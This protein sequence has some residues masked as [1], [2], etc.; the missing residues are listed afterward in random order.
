MRAAGAQLIVVLSHM[1]HEELLAEL[2]RRVLELGGVRV[3]RKRHLEPQSDGGFRHGG[4]VA[5]TLADRRWAR[6]LCHAPGRAP[7]RAAAGDRRVG[8]LGRR[9]DAHG[10]GSVRAAMIPGRADG[11]AGVHG[12]R[13]ELVMASL[14]GE[15]SIA[16]LCR[17]PR[18][19][20]EMLAQW[21]ADDDYQR[22]TSHE[23]PVIVRERR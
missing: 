20:Q 6:Q 22:N 19:W 16:E 4:P 3:A 5:A 2:R 21:P 11:R 1:I 8:A 15:R 23:I 9:Q 12:R 18:L 10:G 14:R 17:E 7:G 13:R